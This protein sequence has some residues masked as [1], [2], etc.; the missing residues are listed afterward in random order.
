MKPSSAAAEVTRCRPALGTYVRVRARAHGRAAAL[1]ACE[2]AFRAIAR[3]EGL[4]SYHD[5][6]S[7]LS[8]M[9]RGAARK[10]VRASPDTWRVLRAAARLWSASGGVFDPAVAPVLERWGYL[11]PRGPAVRGG[12][13]DVE[14]RPGR[15][16]RFRRPL[17]IDLG[18]IAKGY[19][20][21]AAVAALRR[22]GARAGCVNAGGDLR[23]FGPR[24]ERVHVRDPRRPWRL[25]PAASVR[26]GAFATSSDHHAAR[27]SGGRRVHPLVRPGTG[28]PAPAG[29]SVSVSA[30]SC[31]WA[32]GLT[33]LA[34]LMGRQAEPIL[35]AFGAEAH[36]FL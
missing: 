5:P 29:W 27:R 3:V 21:D 9:N 16:V 18:G 12:W 10:A 31:V 26:D 24:A 1:R 28:R 33:K 6:E 17:R 15:L 35:G 32:D 20:V 22:A 36:V 25:L 4:M 23:V 2:A 7:E 19:A 13:R 14:L 30:P 11:P 34:W 8:R